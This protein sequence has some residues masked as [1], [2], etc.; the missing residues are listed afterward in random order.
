MKAASTEVSF[1]TK[2][3]LDYTLGISHSLGR[4]ARP[5]RENHKISTEIIC[6]SPL[7]NQAV[8][9][10]PGVNEIKQNENG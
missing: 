5:G 6:F 7:P 2:F 4:C 10:D 1:I 9:R 3:R 8:P